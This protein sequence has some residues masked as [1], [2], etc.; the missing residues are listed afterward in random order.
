VMPACVPTID[1]RPPA[2]VAETTTGR[3][4]PITPR[5]AKKT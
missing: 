1:R 4:I 5:D 3:T 2:V